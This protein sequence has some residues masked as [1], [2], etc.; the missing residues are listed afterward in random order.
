MAVSEELVVELKG[1]SGDLI[2]SLKK[3]ENQIKGFSEKSTNKINKLSGA[4]KALA[5]AIA[6]GAIARFTKSTMDS[7]DKIGKLSTRLAI[8]TEALSQLRHVADQSGVSFETMST[9]LQRQTR[10]ISEATSGTGVAVKALQELNL[11]A[12]ELNKLAPDKQYE[13]ISE[14]LN[15]MARQSDKVRLAMALFDTEGVALLQTMGSGAKG[16]QDLRTEADKLGMTLSEID[17]RNVEKAN[18]TLDSF[19]K[20]ISSTFTQAIVAFAPAIEK[21]SALLLEFSLKLRELGNIDFLILGKKLKAS[22]DYA[23]LQVKTFV[24]DYRDYLSLIGGVAEVKFEEVVAEI[25]KGSALVVKQARLAGVEFAGITSKIRRSSYNVKANKEAVEAMYN[26]EIAEIDLGTKK[27]VDKIKEDTIDKI[28]ARKEALQQ[29]SEELV[30]FISN[31]KAEEITRKEGKQEK[32]QTPV[33]NDTEVGGGDLVNDI[34][35]KLGVPNPEEAKTALQAIKDLNEEYG[36]DLAAVGILHQERE[37]ENLQ[38]FLTSEYDITAEH[39]AN[40][41][42]LI[43]KSEDEILRIRKNANVAFLMA[44]NDNF[45][46]ALSNFATGSKKMFEMNKAAK[47]G[48]AVV[49]GYSAVQKAWLSGMSVGGP[50]APVIAAGYAASAAAVSASRIAQ[51]KSS[52]Y[53]GKGGGGGGG[54]GANT[55]SSQQQGGGSS[56]PQIQKQININLQGET[57]G[58]STVRRLIESI[59]DEQQN[60]TKIMVMA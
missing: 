8:S 41:E 29:E 22:F 45:Q 11:S 47:I 20:S 16:I 46:E 13:K 7:V 32:K 9:A 36:L 27:V 18:D 12:K 52:K 39:R 10:R 24:A 51:I 33:K 26:A 2:S 49:D 59:N 3:S 21:M 37:I 19:S 1:E 57:F 31:I 5:G 25:K 54:G 23:V 34:Y 30:K 14:A 6:V 56:D 48:E 43:A 53:G 42:E 17:V 44:T 60:G 28:E 4:F 15:G 40:L 58:Q 35:A 38:G 55:A 50:Y